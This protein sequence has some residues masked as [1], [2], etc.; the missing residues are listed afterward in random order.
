MLSPVQCL[1]LGG[2]L[3][4]LLDLMLAVGAENFGHDTHVSKVSFLF[5]PSRRGNELTAGMPQAILRLL[6]YIFLNY[7]RV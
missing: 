3:L 5:R 2:D 7:I 4:Q 6:Y 1:D